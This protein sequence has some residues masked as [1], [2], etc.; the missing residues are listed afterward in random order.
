MNKETI[1]LSDIHLNEK[2]TKIS[3]NF[4]LFLT[5]CSENES[6]IDSIYI[7]GDL[8]EFWIGDD[9]LNEFNQSIIQKLKHISDKVS[10]TYLM[11]GN[12][13]FLI[14]QQFEQNT[15]FNLLPDPHVITLGNKNIILSHGDIYCTDDIA[16]QT[17]RSQVR[18]E[19]WQQHF[20]SKS[21]N[22]RIQ[23]ALKARQESITRQKESNGL[24][25]EYI[26]DVNELEIKSSFSQYNA[27]LIIHGH[28]HRPNKHD[29]IMNKELKIRYVLPAWY[30]QAGFLKYDHQLNQY[31]FIYL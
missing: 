27:D 10:N 31:N 23:I 2:A 29:Y 19:Q 15:G 25:E 22:E 4:E 11:H 30:E 21:I 14:Q 5:Y 13:D 18:N 6:Q 16:Y 26:S 8:F 17:F 12:R 9:F 20:L 7:L 3:E 24:T 28:T 1:F